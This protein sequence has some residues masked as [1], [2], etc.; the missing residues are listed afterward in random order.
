MTR[1]EL[2]LLSAG[3]MHGCSN[4]TRKQIT[5]SFVGASHQIGHLVRGGAIP[6][7]SRQRRVPV[8]I[9]GGGVAGLSAGWQL[10]RNGFHDFEILELEDEAGG[11]ARS[12]ENRVSAYP[13]GAHY[14]PLPTK[15]SRF[16]RELFEELGVIIGY[17]NGEPKYKDEYLCFDPQERLFIHGRWQDGLVPT[18][19]TTDS[20]RE[21]F[22][23]FKDIVDEY[24]ARRA[25]TIPMDFSARDPDLIRLDSTSIR[26]F[27]RD[28]GLN[29]QAL[30]WYV[31]YAC[32]DDYGCNYA[33]VSAWAGI[34]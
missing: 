27:L 15:E 1:R 3:L 26:D 10:A 32:R 9:I 16:V 19:G 13:W 28:R 20:D 31:N 18:V 11:N 2:L 25:F 29:S 5:G 12:G 4:R 14:V 17:E 33:D 21:D 24:K 23:R 8:V 22:Q 30:H 7:P 34:H 6:S